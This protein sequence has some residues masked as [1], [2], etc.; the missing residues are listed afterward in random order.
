MTVN[1]LFPTDYQLH[2]FHEGSLFQSHQLFGAHILNNSEQVV[3]R[4]CV[5]APN[6][7]QVRLV[8]DFNNWNGI[9][10]ELQRVNNEGVW[11]IGIPKNLEGS[12]YKYEIFSRTGERFLKAD[13]YGFFSEIRPNTASM[14]YSLLNYEWQDDEW[15]KRRE[16]ENNLSVPSI[17]YEVHLGSWRKKDNEDFLTYKE[18]AS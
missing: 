4:F 6:A 10:Y 9:G 12:F 18:L 8:G 17:I 16:K 7:E 13:P 11:M 1:T 14:V 5:W 15:L 3:T 2:L